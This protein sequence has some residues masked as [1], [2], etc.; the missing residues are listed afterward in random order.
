MSN[1]RQLL[2]KYIRESNEPSEAGG[3]VQ[4]ETLDK[5]KQTGFKFVDMKRGQARFSPTSRMPAVE[6]F[7]SW[8]KRRGYDVDVSGKDV[9]ALYMGR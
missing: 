9:L 1:A 8:L 5:A 3:Y 4:P 2:E 6:H 7:V